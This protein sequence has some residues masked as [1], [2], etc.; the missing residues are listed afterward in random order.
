MSIDS[1]CILLRSFILFNNLNVINTH[2]NF[3][4]IK[5]ER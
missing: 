1:N 2:T 4:K 5:K 3:I